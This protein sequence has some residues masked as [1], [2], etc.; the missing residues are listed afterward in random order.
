MFK[1]SARFYDVMYGFKDY[2][3]EAQQ[4]HDIAQGH[5]QTDGNR[6]LD[7]ACGTGAH[8]DSL[9]AHY[10]NI[11]A[12]DLDEEILAVAKDRHPDVQFHHADMRTFTLDDR[13]DVI[14]CL[15]S[16]I[17]YAATLADMEQAVANMAAHLVEGGV[18]IIEPWLTP[19]VIMPDVPHMLTVDDP[20]FKLTRMNVT[21]VEGRRTILDFHY[22]VATPDGVDYFTEHHELGL[23][24]VAEYKA[25]LEKAGLH[26]TRDPEGITGRGLYIGVRG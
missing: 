23:F 17:G 1:K 4:I 25:A 15:F 11:H 22:L 10:S 2:P 13:F 6:L 26:V 12:L 8:L 3:A 20:D 24:T 16:S 9:K 7:V 18:L 21:R 5:M 19:D 14:T